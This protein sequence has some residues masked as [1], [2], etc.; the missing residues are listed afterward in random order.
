V[1][2][3]FVSP[4]V[5]QTQPVVLTG[6]QA[7]QVRRVLRLRP[8]ER[9]MMLDNLGSAYD[10][11][12]VGY[13][14]HEARFRIEGQRFAG[15]E[16]A[17]HLTL[18]QAALKG[19][20]FEWLLQKGTEIGASRFVPVICERNVVDDRRA[21]DGKRERW[22]RIIQEAAEQSGRARLP[23]LAPC[24]S[25]A[26]AVGSDAIPTAP[27]GSPSGDMPAEASAIRLIPWEGLRDDGGQRLQKGRS[28]REAL[29][30]CNLR[31]G[32]HIEVF[33]GPEGGFSDAE[34]GLAQ[35]HRILPVSLGPRILRAETAGVVA[36]ATIMYEVGEI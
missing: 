16:P 24:M 25:F 21:V 5:L 33:I 22:Q 12:L 2:R 8:G 36:A 11:V 17:T 14:Q 30:G 7:H 6:E 32:I 26:D 9:V 15:G 28:L 18:F 1:D 20:R 3:F 35:N 34:I 23:E 31:V 13:G 27:K 19:E 4:A 10:A 29:A